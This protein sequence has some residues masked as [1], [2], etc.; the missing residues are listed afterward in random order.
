MAKRKIAKTLDKRFEPD[1]NGWKNYETWNVAL[2][3][4]NDEG[5]N[6]VAMGCSDYKDFVNTM[7]EFEGADMHEED[8]QVSAISLQ[9]PDNVAWNDSGIDIAALDELIKSIKE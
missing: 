2:W 4:N 7:R 6:N 3:I 9:T 5:L 8:T 1:Y